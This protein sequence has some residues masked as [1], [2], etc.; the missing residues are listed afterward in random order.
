MIKGTALA[1]LAAAQTRLALISNEVQVEKHQALR[2]I[3][4]ILALAFCLG[5]AVLLIVAVALTVWWE[6]RVA[7]LV[8]STGLF[9]ALSLY[10]LLALQSLNTRSEP[11]FAASLAELQEDLRQLRATTGNE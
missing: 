5:V 4:L 6:N 11:I 7:V 9:A 2:Q 10:F 1:L 8:V 3:K